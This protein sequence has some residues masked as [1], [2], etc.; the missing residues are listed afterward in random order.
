VTRTIRELSAKEADFLSRLAA[1]GQT[2]FSTAQARAFWGDADYTVNVLN[3]LIRKGW[4]QRLQRGVYMV[5][6]LEAGPQR[7]WSESA[8]V[9]APHLIQPAAVAYW[10]ALHYWNMTEQVPH[11]V[12]VQ[13][14]R[15][16]RPV[17]VLG[18]RFRFVTLSQ[19]RFFGVARRTLDGKPMYVTDREK[20]LLDAAARPD[21]S[22]GVEQLAQALRAVCTDSSGGAVGQSLD[23]A[24]LDDYLARWGGGVVVKRLGYLIE[25]LSVRLSAHDQALRV[26]DLDRRLE[27]WQGLLSRGVS[28]L[29]PAAQDDGPV[30]TRWRIRVNVAV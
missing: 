14:T 22:G 1:D 3:R 16:K 26:P 9:I 18:M 2:I 15:R 8:L 24:R 13:S 5:I 20:T 4:L 6:P 10:S 21:L 30:V 7:T 25:T 28:L 17:E 23:W 12:F 11:T 29:E 27:R 19:A